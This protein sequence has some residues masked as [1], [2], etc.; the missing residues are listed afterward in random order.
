[1]KTGKH[2]GKDAWFHDPSLETQ[3]SLPIFGFDDRPCSSNSKKNSF[4]VILLGI[5]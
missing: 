5:K 2:T 1:M 4:T 3:A